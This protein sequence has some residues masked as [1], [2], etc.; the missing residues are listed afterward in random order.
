MNNFLKTQLNVLIV[1]TAVLI[2]AQA[3]SQEFEAYLYDESIKS[4]VPGIPALKNGIQ[5]DGGLL[6]GRP[7]NIQVV[8]K[9]TGVASMVFTYNGGN[10]R[11]ENELPFTV[12]KETG[13]GNAVIAPGS[14]N[15]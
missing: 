2:S 6:E 11:K 4:R 5:I 12:L 8:P 3:Y 1:L 7:L 15:F 13:Q 14:H 9:F 10:T